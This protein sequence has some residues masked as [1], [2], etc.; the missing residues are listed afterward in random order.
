[1]FV[2]SPVQIVT[3]REINNGEKHI[4]VGY[5]HVLW[6]SFNLSRR[7]Y[8][9]E[10]FSH[11]FFSAICFLCNI[12]ACLD[13][14]LFSGSLP[15]QDEPVG[16]ICL[17]L[18]SHI[19]IMSSCIF[20]KQLGEVRGEPW[21]PHTHFICLVV[22]KEMFRINFNPPSLQSRAS[23]WPRSH[24]ANT[25]C[26]LSARRPPYAHTITHSKPNICSATHTPTHSLLLLHSQTFSQFLTL[27]STLLVS[28]LAPYPSSGCCPFVHSPSLPPS[29][30]STA[31]LAPFPLLPPPHWPHPLNSLHRHAVWRVSE[32][33][34]AGTFPHPCTGPGSRTGP[35]AHSLSHF[36]MLLIR[37][38][39]LL[40]L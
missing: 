28:T 3:D 14:L 30:L 11:S 9:S 17:G 16:L 4:L 38:A 40:E 20:Y 22:K 26:Q 18:E 21:P 35:P 37:A 10:N 34:A 1:M 27:L 19:P 24:S 23:G 13:P 25:G 36:S 5:V 31:S 39:F 33:C 6:H 12:T 29:I 32:A 15:S 2:H 8:P 7:K